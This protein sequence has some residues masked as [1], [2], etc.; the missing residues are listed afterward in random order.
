MCAVHSNQKGEFHLQFNPANALQAK[1]MKYSN[2][3]IPDTKGCRQKPQLTM[4]RYLILIL[5][6][7]INF[8]VLVLAHL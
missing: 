4:K 5:R 2:V 7:I 1:L 6:R 8:K 3:Q